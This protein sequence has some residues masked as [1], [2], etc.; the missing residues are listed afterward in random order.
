MRKDSQAI[1]LLLVSDSPERADALLRL[2]RQY[3]LNGELHRVRPGRKA[4]AQ[5]RRSGRFRH[6]RQHDIVLLDFAEPD[7]RSFATLIEIAFRNTP[8]QAPVV[9]LTSSL[10]EEV[11]HTAPLAARTEELFEPLG[12]F[13]F[14]TKMGEHARG[15]FLRAL[16]V[17]GEFGPVLV[18]LPQFVANCGDENMAVPGVVAPEQ[19]VA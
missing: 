1:R 13:E 2:M 16:N 9:M 15:R 11:L 7:E 5:A 8:D 18:R 6:S 12:L 19:R 14:F 17:I 4:V 10:S 3:D